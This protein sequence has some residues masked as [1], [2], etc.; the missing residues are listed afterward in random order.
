MREVLLL[1]PHWNKELTSEM[2]DRE[3]LVGKTM[4]Q[5]IR[6]W[7]TDTIWS[8]EGS[9]GRGDRSFV[10]YVRVFDKECS[11]SAQSGWY[12][13]YLFADDGSRVVLSLNQGTHKIG[14][15]AVSDRVEW[16]RSLLKSRLAD[17]KNL[18]ETIKITDKA[19]GRPS[20]YQGAN[21]V[22]F[23][24]ER[25]NIPEDDELTQDLE[26][27]L[28]MLRMV[29]DEYHA[30]FNW[31]VRETLWPQAELRELSEIID[32]LNKW[33]PQVVFAG[34]P[35]TGKTHVAEKVG[36]HLTEGNDSAVH[37][38]QFHP[39]YAYEDFVEGLRPTSTDNGQIAFETLAGRLVNIADEARKSDQ[40][41]VLVIDEMNRA[42]L[43]SVFG[44][45]LYLLEYRGKE[46][47]LL[48]RDEFSLPPNLYIIGTMNTADRSIR[49]ID[50]ALRRRFHI[51]EFQP[52]PSMLAAYYSDQSRT[53]LLSVDVADGLEKLND[54]LTERLD[55]H[56]TIGHSFFMHATLDQAALERTWNRQ[57]KPLIEE[58]FFDQ[59]D[60]VTE[61]SQE[62]FWPT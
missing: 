9:G 24:Y 33:Q 54:D 52:K 19:K 6:E 30:T 16:A 48:H 7:L 22:A 56:H 26:Y 29:L 1:Q 60:V 57:V 31:L 38:I 28:T 15:K 18:R 42:N 61:F 39:S 40:P 13:A 41:V 11:R 17:D 51:F 36:R 55:R 50:S 25:D 27:M 37:V 34:P 10:P 44:E 12:A 53:N 23:T 14:K 58:Y 49:S 20:D 4:P 35:G 3:E 47:G 2:T 5:V 62:K 32:T 59:P 43:P 8:V 46:I 45:L 21:V